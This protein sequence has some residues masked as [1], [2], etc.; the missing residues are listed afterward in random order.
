MY[1]LYSLT[2]IVLSNSSLIVVCEQKGGFGAQKVKA[3]FKEIESRA[4]QR[5]KERETLAANMAIQEAK[6]KEEQ[7]KQL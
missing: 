2:C 6:T 3:D 4:E 7:E 5:D 1:T